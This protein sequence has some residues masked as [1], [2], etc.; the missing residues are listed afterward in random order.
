MVAFQVG[1]CKNEIRIPTD[2]DREGI[3]QEINAYQDR[4]GEGSVFVTKVFDKT[5]LH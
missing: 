2:L 3:V 5:K 1:R 4:V